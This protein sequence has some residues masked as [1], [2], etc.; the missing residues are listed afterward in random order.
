LKIK[1]II[2]DWF[3]SKDHPY[4]RNYTIGKNGVIKIKEHRAAGEGDKWF[5]DVYFE[6]KHKERIFNINQV[7]YEE[8]GELYNRHPQLDSTVYMPAP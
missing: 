2:Y 4:W 7:I 1:K 3:I 6:D 8:G 5:Y